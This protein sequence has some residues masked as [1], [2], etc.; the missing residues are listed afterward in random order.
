MSSELAGPWGICVLPGSELCV[1][2][3]GASWRLPPRLRMLTCNGEA[4]GELTLPAEFD[5]VQDVMCDGES[6][7]VSDMSSHR[8]ARLRLPDGKVLAVTSGRQGDDHDELKYPRAMAYVKGGESLAHADDLLFICDSG[9]SRVVA[10]AAA[11]LTPLR[12]YGKPGREEIFRE[13]GTPRGSVGDQVEDT[14][15]RLSRITREEELELPLGLTTHAGLLY[16][17]D[18]YQHCLS[19]FRI[20]DSYFVRRI[21]T[22]GQGGAEFQSPTG[23][24]LVRGR[25]VVTE[26]TRVQVQTPA[27]SLIWVHHLRPL[28]LRVFYPRARAGARPQRCTTP[29]ARASVRRQPC[30][31]VRRRRQRL[32]LRD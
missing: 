1:A 16:V 7:W 12:Q 5:D 24:V 27:C 10:Y 14:L 25:L 20:A 28:S 8:V 30:W 2:E 3:R 17:V 29:G 6:L 23:V 26:A 4:R 15:A 19:V 18:G 11:T 22:R 9:N 13:P 21:G 31:R 32:L